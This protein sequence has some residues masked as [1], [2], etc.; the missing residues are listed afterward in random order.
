MP[1][2][3]ADRVWC[4][5]SQSSL[6]NIYFRLS[7]FQ[8]SLRLIHFRYGSNASSH[9]HE[10]WQKFIRYVT[11][12]FQNW[13]RAASFRYRN[14]AEIC[15]LCVNNSP[16]RYSFHIGARAIRHTVNKDWDVAFWWYK[17]DR[18]ESSGELKT[19]IN[20]AYRRSSQQPATQMLPETTMIFQQRKSQT[21]WTRICRPV[22]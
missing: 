1:E 16:S 19:I 3:L 22:M 20:V 5:K 18:S 6:L 21:S 14:R 7:G 4:T 15:S 8:S 2:R 10:K 11:F 13:C 9:C 12:F 17:N